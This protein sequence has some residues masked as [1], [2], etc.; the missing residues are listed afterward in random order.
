MRRRGLFVTVPAAPGVLV[1][2]FAPCVAPFSTNTTTLPRHVSSVVVMDGFWH[3]LRWENL[4][5]FR[6]AV[7]QAHSRDGGKCSDGLIP[8]LV[9]LKS[10]AFALQGL[11]T[12][13]SWAQHQP[14]AL[15]GLVQAVSR[16]EGG[17]QGRAR[18]LW[19]TLSSRGGFGTSLPLAPSVLGGLLAPGARLSG[20]SNTHQPFPPPS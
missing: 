6:R 17:S 8:V 11:G 3:K 5:T 2:G 18:E 4:A 19:D 16:G 14:R 7:T 20:L 13:S 15:V 12:G 9:G 1:S 10:H